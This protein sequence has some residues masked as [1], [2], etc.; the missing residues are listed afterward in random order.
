MAEEKLLTGTTAAN[1]VNDVFSDYPESVRKELWETLTMPGLQE[2]GVRDNYKKRLLGAYTAYK[3]PKDRVDELNEF[4]TADI[5]GRLDVGLMERKALERRKKPASPAPRTEQ[6]PQEAKSRLAPGQVPV[7]LEPLRRLGATL[8]GTF[9]KPTAIGEMVYQATSPEYRRYHSTVRSPLEVPPLVDVSQL[10]ASKAMPSG[11]FRGLTRSI[12]ENV[13]ALASPINA[14]IGGG[15]SQLRAIPSLYKAAGGAMAAHMAQGIPDATKRLQ[16]A[17]AKGDEEEAIKAVADITFGAATMGLVAKHTMEGGGKAKSGSAGKK[18]PTTPP[19]PSAPPPAPPTAGAPAQPSSSLILTAI[20]TESAKDPISGKPYSVEIVQDPF[21]KREIVLEPNEKA[22]HIGETTYVFRPTGI[23]GSYEVDV[24]SLRGGRDRAFE[25]RLEKVE[26]IEDAARSIHEKNASLGKEP[27]PLTPKSGMP[28]QT[29]TTPSGPSASAKAASVGKTAPSPAGGN[30]PAQAS[31]TTRPA[32][33]GK[34]KAPT[35]TAPVETASTPVSE[36]VTPSGTESVYTDIPKGKPQRNVFIVFESDQSKALYENIQNAKLSDNPGLKAAAQAAYDEYAQKYSQQYN[37]TIEQAKKILGRW[38]DETFYRAKNQPT[39]IPEGADRLQVEAKPIPPPSAKKRATTTPPP[40]PQVVDPEKPAT[41]ETVADSEV[42]VPAQESVTQTTATEVPAKPKSTKKKATE[43]AKTAEVAPEESISGD[44]YET[45]DGVFVEFDRGS[46]AAMAVSGGT[47]QRLLKHIPKLNF[48]LVDGSPIVGNQALSLNL[49]KAYRNHISSM[50]SSGKAPT[51]EQFA[52]DIWEDRGKVTVAKS[53]AGPKETSTIRLST[54]EQIDTRINKIKEA[55][56]LYQRDREKIPEDLSREL[57]TLEWIKSRGYTGELKTSIPADYQVEA[58]EALAN[59]RRENDSLSRISASSKMEQGRLAPLIAGLQE[60]INSLKQMMADPKSAPPQYKEQLEGQARAYAAEIE[61]LEKQNGAREKESKANNKEIKK[62]TSRMEKMDKEN[63]KFA[64]T[65]KRIN[66]LTERN[67]D[68]AR[69]VGARKS[70]SSWLSEEIKKIQKELSLDRP[71]S[72][73]NYSA[74]EARLA[75]ELKRLKAESLAL[76]QRGKSADIELKEASK[77]LKDFLKTEQGKRAVEIEGKTAAELKAEQERIKAAESR[78]TRPVPEFQYVIPR[79]SGAFARKVLEEATSREVTAPSEPTTLEGL[80]RVE[81][82]VSS[83]ETKLKEASS[84]LNIKKEYERLQKKKIE[85]AEA[86]VESQ[87]SVV[88]TL[89]GKPPTSGAQKRAAADLEGAKE[90]LAARERDLSEAQSE[91]SKG[92]HSNLVRK[93]LEKKI[94]NTN[95]S[96]SVLKETMARLNKIIEKIPGQPETIKAEEALLRAGK[97]K[98]S[99]LTEERKLEQAKADLQS[100]RERLEKYNKEQVSKSQKEVSELDAL[101]EKAKLEQENMRSALEGIT[102][103][104]Q[105]AEFETNLNRYT[106]TIAE[107]ESKAAQL[108]EKFQKTT[109]VTEEVAT[110]K[111]TAPQSAID[112]AFD[113]AVSMVKEQGSISRSQ[114]QQAAT[115]LTRKQVNSVLERLKAEG[116]VDDNLKAIEKPAPVAE[117]KPV[118]E[119]P[120]P[121]PAAKKSKPKPAAKEK[122]K[123]EERKPAEIKVE[124]PETKPESEVKPKAKPAEKKPTQSKKKPEPT[125]KPPAEKPAKPQA[126]K[127]TV[128][129]ERKQDSE[130]HSAWRKNPSGFLYDPDAFSVR[131]AAQKELTSKGFAKDMV[132]AGKK[133]VDYLKYVDSIKTGKAKSLEEW[134]SSNK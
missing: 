49:I 16:D 18:P 5:N 91:L 4:K 44:V 110:S 88:D 66:S 17:L 38:A 115:D 41:E 80:G 95:T 74:E 116:I 34:Q 25:T 32:T 98:G 104:E 73:S 101:I 63:P 107:L 64:N 27:Q 40:A 133:M 124:A 127:S 72:Y 79:R 106:N 1:Y 75:K 45:K 87:Q 85:A 42:A 50:E 86:K 57:E 103:V 76:R 84:R 30:T 126:E 96:I 132:E 68:I 20:R 114:L 7:I 77:E 129:L 99:L 58:T 128:D 89:S 22:V 21:T 3:L 92:G 93:S 14:L 26:S 51:I 125:E 130:L 134:A 15:M 55:L 56:A 119:E 71:A 113:Q 47:T 90:A 33:P 61:S 82:F 78:P 2:E 43:T 112:S 9:D 19:P 10:G 97:K 118:V 53:P 65:Q 35:S 111:A 67:N 11:G 105:R 23:R 59:L 31:G 100:R 24:A 123:A 52:K 122:P 131:I 28:T 108:R 109:A 83:L 81:S 94:E 37:V 29:T 62:L 48:I 69:E 117:S 8:L 39:E 60:R 54:P 120:K 12:E 36:A 121:K 46:D 6:P 102:D 13:S 70:R